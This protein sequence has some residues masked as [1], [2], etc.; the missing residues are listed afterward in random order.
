[1]RMHDIV[2]KMWLYLCLTTMEIG[3]VHGPSNLISLS[4]IVSLAIS[5]Y[6]S[7]NNF[8]ILFKSTDFY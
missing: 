2:C 3:G 4:V 8:F 6:S 7:D 1:M 5:V